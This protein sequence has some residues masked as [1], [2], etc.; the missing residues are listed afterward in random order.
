ME[1]LLKS[2]MKKKHHFVLTLLLIIFILFDIK[3]P[4]VF[5]EL[6]DNPVGKIVVAISALCLLSANKLAGV[7]GI[8]AAF[9]LLQRVADSTGTHAKNVY[10]PTEHKKSKHL[11]SM[12][13]FPITVEEEIISKM[14]PTTNFRD[15]TNPEFKPVLDDNHNAAVSN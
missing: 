13:Q 10:L 5:A 14:L 9:I 2:L 4:L 6:V 15:F 11:S 8:V 3:I 7:I 1:N 12:N